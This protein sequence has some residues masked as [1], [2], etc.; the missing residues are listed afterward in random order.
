LNKSC[1]YNCKIIF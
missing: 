1:L